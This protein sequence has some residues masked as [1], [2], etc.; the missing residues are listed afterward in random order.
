[1]LWEIGLFVVGT[2]IL[3]VCYWKFNELENHMSLVE[4]IL[5]SVTDQLTKAKDEINARIDE[6]VAQVD[7]GGVSPETIEALRSAA[8][9]LDDVVPD[10]PPPVEEEPAPPVEENP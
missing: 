2:A 6:L 1:M 7:A 4:D 9:G 10:I 8:Q 5:R 3:V